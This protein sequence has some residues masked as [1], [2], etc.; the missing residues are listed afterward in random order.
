MK[1]NS[2]WQKFIDDKGDFEFPKYLYKTHSELMKTVLDL[3]T[4]VCQDQ[5]KLRAYKERVKSAFKQRWVDVASAFEFFDIMSPCS[6]SENDFCT[7]CGGSR[8]ILNTALSADEMREAAMFLDASASAE[9][10]EKLQKGL[11]KALKEVKESGR[12]L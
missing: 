2:D 4:L 6:C 1:S 8:F 7:I 5:P 12:K 10:A 11:S 3:G 9:L